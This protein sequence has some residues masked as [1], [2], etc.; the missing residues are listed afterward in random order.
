[1][2]VST[3]INITHNHCEEEQLAARQQTRGMV[4]ISCSLRE[5][6]GVHPGKVA[7]QIVYPL[8]SILCLFTFFNRFKGN[9]FDF[10]SRFEN[11][12]F[13][14]TSTQKDYLHHHQQLNDLLPSVSLPAI[15]ITEEAVNWVFQYQKR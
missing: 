3:I 8:F 4:P 11:Q 6:G 2:F 7:G 13:T 9:K 5:R 14:P 10:F 15:N 12:P 1:M